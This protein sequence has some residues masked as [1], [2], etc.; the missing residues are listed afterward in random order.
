MNGSNWIR[1]VVLAV[2]CLILGFV[3]GW[4]LASMGGD[5]VKLPD[6]S[7]DVTVQE[8]APRTDTPVATAEQPTTAAAPD[9]AGVSVAVLNGSGV[10]GRAAQ[11]ATRLKGV[12]YSTVATGDAP[13]R[14]GNVVYYRADQKPA[15]DQLA[16]DLQI[17]EVTAIEGSP[18]A[19]SAPASAQVV[20][21]LGT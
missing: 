12:G 16:S 19:T 11:T 2:S 10:T 13:R 3:G 9:R 14:S 21:V 18:V 5:T 20:V 15:A 4:S 17:T 6:A 8:P 1:P 7:V